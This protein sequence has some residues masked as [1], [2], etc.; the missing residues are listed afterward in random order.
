MMKSTLTG[1]AGFTGSTNFID[2]NNLGKEQQFPN[3]KNDSLAAWHETNQPSINPNY[4]ASE[5]SSIPNDLP[6]SYD[7]DSYQQEH[8]D[9]VPLNPNPNTSFA[10]VRHRDFRNVD[11][12]NSHA[13]DDAKTK[14]VACLR[15]I[16]NAHLIKP[17][18]ATPT[19]SSSRTGLWRYIPFINID[20]RQYS[21]FSSKTT[22]INNGPNSPKKGK[23]KEGTE[24]KEDAVF[25]L[26]VKVALA[27]GGAIVAFVAARWATKEVVNKEEQVD[28]FAQELKE[29]KAKFGKGDSQ[30]AINRSVE[31]AESILA[32]NY[33]A[34]VTNITA[35]V[36]LGLSGLGIIGGGIASAPAVVVTS[37]GVSG[38]A[39]LTLLVN[40]TYDQRRQNQNDRA[41]KFINNLLNLDQQLLQQAQ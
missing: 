29:C 18:G 3:E 20:N 23:G 32:R 27:V 31:A 37:I 5:S 38:V 39:L 30:S 16:A 26:G 15:K 24:I 12:S 35:Y 11:S 34:R 10:P 13:K 14:I 22:V 4:S 8:T 21:L 33:K 17:V 7:E 25:S 41:A 36:G 9:P 2:P 28:D 40:S 19:T 1:P 6:P